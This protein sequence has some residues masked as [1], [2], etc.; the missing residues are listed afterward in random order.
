MPLL[1]VQYRPCHSNGQTWRRTL[2]ELRTPET[3]HRADGFFLHPATVSAAHLAAHL[4]AD[5]RSGAARAGAG[6]PHS[7]S[8]SGNR[9]QTTNLRES[10]WSGS[11]SGGK[12][13]SFDPNLVCGSD[14]FYA[15]FLPVFL[16]IWRPVGEVDIG[17]SCSTLGRMSALQIGSRAPPHMQ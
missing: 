11:S 6:P 5:G 3:L 8:I 16:L 7:P 14:G 9:G 15:H 2:S 4:A 17:S 10:K 1:G 12:R 13:G